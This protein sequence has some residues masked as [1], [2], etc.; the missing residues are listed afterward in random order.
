MG[1]AKVFVGKSM[2]YSVVRRFSL[3]LCVM[4][5][6]ARHNMVKFKT[7]DRKHILVFM[8]CDSFGWKAYCFYGNIYF[9]IKILVISEAQS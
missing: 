8:K 4:L 5:C 6:T 7:L 2:L 3:C 1:L 9:E